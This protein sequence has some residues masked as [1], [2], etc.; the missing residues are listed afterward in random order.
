MSGKNTPK[1]ADPFFTSRRSGKKKAAKKKPSTPTKKVKSSPPSGPGW[2][3]VG[4]RSLNKPTCLSCKGR[5][6]FRKQSKVKCSRCK[7]IGWIEGED[8]SEVICPGCQGMRT[9]SKSCRRPCKECDG[10]G[11]FVQIVQRFL[12]KVTCKECSGEGKKMK[13]LKCPNCRGLGFHGS[14]PRERDSDP[15]EFV[16]E[17]EWIKLGGSK[18]V[19]DKNRLDEPWFDP[20]PGYAW[21]LC[22][23]SPLGGY[24]VRF[25]RH[26]SCYLCE[27]TGQS[28]ETMLSPCEACSGSGSVEEL[29]TRAV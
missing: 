29:E 19:I 8:G 13:Y 17:E 11:H 3:V 16:S 26:P 2:K 27:G 15:H 25:Q 1:K 9:R 6:H 24:C 12:R 23:K 4:D 5:G 28:S 20:I 7:G 10:R 21:A 22:E 14:G 18:R